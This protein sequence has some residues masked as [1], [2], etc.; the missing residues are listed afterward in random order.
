MMSNSE[1]AEIESNLKKSASKKDFATW[2]ILHRERYLEYLLH[3]AEN[4]E[5]VCGARGAIRILDRCLSILEDEK[6]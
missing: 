3:D 5:D 6:N 2:A 1:I 4:F